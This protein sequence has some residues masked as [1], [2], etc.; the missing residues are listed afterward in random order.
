MGITKVLKNSWKYLPIGSVIDFINNSK[1]YEPKSGKDVFACAAK[2]FAHI[3]YTASPFIFLLAASQFGT[4]NPIKWSEIAKERRE[5]ATALQ[6][7]S[8]CVNRDGIPGL[9]YA[10]LT[11]LY[12]TAGIHFD[13][14]RMNY[15]I[16]L[17][18]KVAI[19]EPMNQDGWVVPKPTQSQLEAVARS[20]PAPRSELER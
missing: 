9:S 13:P 12:E 15:R 8:A 16:I 20:C 5:Y 7:A 17:Q 2:T 19:A 18:G 6:N 3:A 14:L 10:E 11:N 4:P 1:F